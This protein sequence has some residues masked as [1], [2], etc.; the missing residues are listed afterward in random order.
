MSSE[1][2][3]PFVSEP[4]R[5]LSVALAAWLACIGAAASDDAVPATDD[6]FESPAHA[7]Q[8]Q[9]SLRATVDRV[10][11]AVVALNRADGGGPLGSGVVIDPAGIVLSNGHSGGNVGDVARVRFPDGRIVSGE[12]QSTHEGGGRDCAVVRITEPGPY[13]FVPL[14]P[15]K[16]SAKTG[17]YC[18]HLGF[19]G[20]FDAESLPTPLL[21]F[22]RISGTGKVSIYANC[23]IV[24]SDSGGPLFDMH[25]RLLGIANYSIGP[26]LR[27]PGQWAAIPQLLDGRTWFQ[28]ANGDE[29]LEFGFTKR[30]R[31]GPDTSRVVSQPAFTA[32]LEPARRATVQVL[33][34]GQPAILGTVVAPGG[35]VLTKRSEVLNSTGQPIGKL[36]CRTFAPESLIESVTVRA[37]FPLDDVVFLQVGGGDREI[38]A[39]DIRPLEV[40]R[41]TILVVPVPGEAASEIGVIGT[42]RPM[43]IERDPGVLPL[44]LE[45]SPA[46]VRVTRVPQAVAEETANAVQASDVVTHVNGMA[47]AT[48]AECASAVEKQTVAAGETV[49]LTL[50]RDERELTCI[51]RAD[52]ANLQNRIH[53]HAH[54][55]VSLR[56]NGF[57]S[58]LCHDAIVAGA[59]CGG[60]IVDLE[61]HIIGVNIARVQ[62]CSTLALP[63]GRVLELLA[64]LNDASVDR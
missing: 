21:R 63:G 16:L 8:I 20:A 22:G 31:T 40:H 5:K 48:V 18:F 58:V 33:V 28:P 50:R 10:A 43:K 42:D 54:A 14:Q 64:Q 38:A 45:K 41:G 46:G 60:P 27:H 52:S 53:Q 29:V 32:L 39:A 1:P 56:R 36:A 25:G 6:E 47:V 49:V 30:D 17:D 37:E 62:R 19:P 51:V 24:F 4:A 9:E 26:Q 12:Y 59:N 34:D 3:R 55:R 23:L 44:V 7:R 2:M 57:P 11:P 15:D 35:I 13:P 61:G